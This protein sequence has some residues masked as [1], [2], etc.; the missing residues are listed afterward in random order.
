MAAELKCHLRDTCLNALFP[1][2][3]VYGI[4]AVVYGIYSSW[5]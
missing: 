5:R 1:L 3:V 4:F 2:A